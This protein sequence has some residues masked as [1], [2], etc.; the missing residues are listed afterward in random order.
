MAR[1]AET[2]RRRVEESVRLLERG[3]ELGLK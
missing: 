2:V 1:R 3:E